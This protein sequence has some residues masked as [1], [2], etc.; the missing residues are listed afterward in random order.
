MTSSPTGSQESAAAPSTVATDLSRAELLRALSFGLL[1]VVVAG[2]LGWVAL[3]ALGEPAASIRPVFY[4]IGL[5]GA[6]FA[7]MATV[8]LHGRL[9]NLRGD[10]G[11]AATGR[12]MAARIQAL[13]AAGFAVKLGVLVVGVFGLRQFSIGEVPTKFADLATFAVTFAAAA[14]LCQVTTAAFMARSMRQP[15]TQPPTH[16]D[17]L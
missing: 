5:A 8:W 12:L 7:G 11:A 17:A 15:R 13:L 2:V 10:L 9:A 6:L 4:L 1:A 14:L 16:S 3:F